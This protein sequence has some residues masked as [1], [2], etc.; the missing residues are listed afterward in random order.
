MNVIVS[1]N[2]QVLWFSN[3]PTLKEMVFLRPSWLFDVLKQLF[4]HD[5]ESATFTPDDSLKAIAFTPAK[6]ERLKQELLTDG[7]VDKEL[8]KGLLV[9]LIP[10]DVNKPSTCLLYTSPSPRDCIVSRM[11]SSA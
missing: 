6:F 3:V 10:A 8:L 1:P 9:S 4:R 7:V 2:L 5:L 11:P